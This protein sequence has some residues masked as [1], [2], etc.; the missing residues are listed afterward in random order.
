MK[1]L[2]GVFAALLLATPAAAD[3][4]SDSG[5]SRT[6]KVSAPGIFEYSQ[7]TDSGAATIVCAVIP[8]HVT[9]G[10]VAT[11]GC[12]SSPDPQQVLERP[13]RDL[14][15]IDDQNVRFDGHVLTA[16]GSCS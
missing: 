9:S 10:K 6:L 5:C 7:R 12:I 11:L 1:A 2:L 16:T 8:S 15:K 4:W 13:F 14:E 3:T